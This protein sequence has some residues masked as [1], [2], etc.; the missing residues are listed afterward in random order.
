MCCG[1]SNVVLSRGRARVVG[2]QKVECA[3]GS[4]GD[5]TTY[6]P[7]RG[8]ETRAGASTFKYLG[9]ALSWVVSRAGEQWDHGG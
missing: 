7:G 5:E 6:T 1:E 9:A 3:R 8:F 2:G 4:V